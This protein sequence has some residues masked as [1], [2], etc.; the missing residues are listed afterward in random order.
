MK[1]NHFNRR[2]F[3]KAA[4]FGSLAALGTGMIPT[5]TLSAV[6][7]AEPMK[8]TKIEAVKP[9]SD[10]RID[11]S[12]PNYLWVRLYTN[13][14]IVGIG[15]TYPFINGHIGILKDLAYLFIGKDPRDIE[16]LW[17]DALVRISYY[18]VGGSDIRIL[19]AINIAQWDILGKALGVPIYR[20]LGG[21]A[22]RKLRIY[23]TTTNY[24]T[25]NDMKPEKDIENITKFLL[26]RGIKAIKIY[27][28]A[29]VGGRNNGNYISPADL[30]N[31]LGWIKRIRDTAGYEMDIGL[32][33]SGRWNLACALRIAESL[34]P[35]RIMWLEDVMLQDNV[36]SYAI[37]ARETSIPI[38]IGER[39]ATRYQF[40]E[41]FES[42][43]VDIVMY[44]LTWCGGISEAKKISDMA[45]AYYIPT[46]PHT[47]GGPVLWYASIHTA[48][49]LTN[50]FIMESCYHFYHHEY[51]YFIKNVPVPEDGF[52]TVP[53]GPGL[54]IE[55]R[56]EP[57]E[58][59]DVIVEKIAEI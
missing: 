20:L 32:D 57:F 3:L 38:C 49:A 24:W 53:E 15:E 9:R 50:F 25:I 44:D 48:T 56:P 19:T 34:E 1:Q 10:L 55:F 30:E 59:G 26:N 4:G 7:N 6:N 52:V 18:P 51:P 8:I 12:R 31:C 45:D 23:N 16:R 21:K 54:G 22:Q 47:C 28:Y 46:A 29:E 5:N 43:A 40:R 58:R 17:R 42:K 35:Y 36:Q 14:G 33:L 13:N 39:C 41:M 2:D 37:L 27:P 11:G